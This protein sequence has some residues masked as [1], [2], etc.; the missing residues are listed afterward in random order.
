MSRVL[1]NLV[2]EIYQKNHV[3]YVVYLSQEQVSRLSN[4]LS[5]FVCTYMQINF[6]SSIYNINFSGLFCLCLANKSQVGQL[7]LTLM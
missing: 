6:N 1:V 4:P 2:C 3:L 5:F 7:I